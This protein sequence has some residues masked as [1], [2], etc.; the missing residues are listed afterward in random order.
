MSLIEGV[1]SDPIAVSIPSAAASRTRRTTPPRAGAPFVSVSAAANGTDSD[2]QGETRLVRVFVAAH[3]CLYREALTDVLARESALEIVGACGERAEILAGVAEVEPDIVLLD[4][5][6]AE[7]LEL[8][9]KLAAPAARVKIVALAASEDER[10]VVAYAEAGVSGF[11][12]REESVADLVAT[13]LRAAKGELV[14]SPQMAGALLRRVTLLA[15]E[16]PTDLLEESLTPRELEVALLLDEGLSN[17]QI[18]VRLQLEVPTV[19]HHVHHI[20]QKLGAAS[21]SEA[22]ARLRQRGL[23]VDAARPI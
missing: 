18:A 2:V 11:V 5:A 13:I 10:D 1:E 7:S 17:K 22:V 20:L 9:R 6:A 4:P 3:V 15:T 23:L 21:R 8:I 12:A 14:C 16:R 19:K